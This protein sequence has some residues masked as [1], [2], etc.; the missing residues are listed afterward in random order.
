MTYEE[1]IS[2]A[3]NQNYQGSNVSRDL[4]NLCQEDSPLMVFV[5]AI[6]QAREQMKEGLLM[7]EFTSEE[8][9]MRAIGSQA[10]IQGIDYV[11]RSLYRLTQQEPTEDDSDG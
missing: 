6:W 2:R 7:Q 9:R 5:Q 3:V 10:Q 8:G 4:R 11:L 1:F